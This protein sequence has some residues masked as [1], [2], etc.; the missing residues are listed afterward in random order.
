MRVRLGTANA[1]CRSSG[2]LA[3]MEIDPERGSY[4]DGRN[5]MSRRRWVLA[6]A[7]VTGVIT[8][9]T[10]AFAAT[11]AQVVRQTRTSTWSTPSSDPTGIAYNP[12]TRNFLISDAEVDESQQLWRKRNLFVVGR[13]G[14][15]LATRRVTKFS[16]EPEG[17]AWWGKKNTLFFADDDRDGI[18]RIKPGRDGK[19]GTLDDTGGKLVN[20]RRWGSFDP[21]G[22]TWRAISKT[23]IWVDA[24]D[25]LVY[26]LRQGPDRRFGSR[27][28]RVTRFGTFKY[29]FTDPEGVTY[30]VASGYLFLASSRNDFLIQTTL[31]GRRVRTIQMPWCNVGCNISDLVF[32]PGTDGSRRRLYLLDRGKDNDAHPFPD[33]NDGKLYQVRFRKV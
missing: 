6:V 27:D 2:A 10:P 14:G 12:R 32:A 9:A 24:T 22:L 30:D 17:L 15:L 3:T 7:V 29:G 25:G 11:E 20:T 21:E 5:G 23:L 18:F 1:W 26:K 31:G 8:A 19:I 28:D 16:F 4:T 33:Y 13:G